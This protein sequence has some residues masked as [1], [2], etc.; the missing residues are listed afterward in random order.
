MIKNRKLLVRDLTLRDGQ[1][2]LFATRMPQ[3]E[4]E[5]VLPLYKKAGFYALEVWGGAVPD[6]VMRYLNE[7]PW[8]RLESIK[9][10]IGDVSK[11]TALSRGRNLFGYSPY[12]ESV[13]EK[14]NT[15][16]VKSGLGIM[17]I[18][19]CL[20][21][22]ENMKSTIKYVKAAGGIADCAVCYTVDSKF[23]EKQEDRD[24]MTIKNL[25]N[26]IFDLEYFVD[27]AKKL[28]AMGAD[29]ISLKDMA[30]LASPSRAGQIIRRFKE[31][32][33][34][35][36]DFHSHSTPGYGLASALTAII[37]GVD[38]IDTNIMNFAGGSAAPAYELI[39]LFCQKLGI[40]LDGDAKT[41][42]EINKILKEIR[43]GALAEVDSY[44]QFP[45]EFDITKDKLPAEI[46][47]LFVDAIEYAKAD[48]EDEL[49]VAC[50]AIEKYFNFPAPNEMVKKAEIPGGMYTNMLNQLKSLGLETLL[51]RVLEVVPVVRL[52]AGCPPLVTPSSQIIGVQAVNCVIDENSGRPFYTN[53]NNQ[54]FNLV[55][56]EYGTT[57]I[58]IA[59]EFRKRIT[60]KAEEAAY[61]MDK[62]QAPENPILSK[63]G[64]VKLAID[65]KE[66]MLLELFPLVAKG[67]LEGKRKVEFEAKREANKKAIAADRS[68]IKRTAQLKIRD[69]TLRDGQQSLFATR[70]PQH[71][72]EKVL[73]FYKDAKFY[74][75]EVWG[76]AIP[77]S[78]M[79]YLNE[80]P[81]YRLESIKEVIGDVSYLTALSRGRNL[82]GY[83]PYPESVIEGFNKNAVKSGLG[84][85]RIFDCLN[86]VKNMET[87]IKYIKEAGGIADCAV[88]Y[89]VDPK[90]TRKQRI[91][92]V[93]SGK[94]LPKKIFDVDYFLNKAKQMEALGADMISVKDMAGLIPPSLSGQIIKRLKKEVKV[95]IDFHTH[96]T[97][98][99]G[100][101]AVL[102]AIINGVDIVDT[103]ILNFAGGPAAPA[104]EII[105]IFADKLGLDTGVDLDAVVKINAELKGIRE[106][107][108]EFDSYKMFPREFD[109]TADYLPA[110]IDALFDK[111]IVLAKADK[112]AE[113][114]EVC[115]AIDVWFNFP[116]PNEEVKAAEIPGGMYTNMLAQLKGLGLE[117]LLPTVLKKVPEVRVAAGCPPLVTPS[118]QIIGVQAVN[119]VLDV[120][121]GKAPY[122]NVNN[123]F[124]N[125][126]KGEYGETPIDIDPDYRQKIC[127]QR[128]ATAYDVSKYKAPENL[129]LEEFGGVKL[130]QNEKEMLLLE[131]FPTV[132]LPYLKNL[133]AEAYYNEQAEIEEQKQRE[134]AERRAAFDG[135]TAEQKE[136]KVLKALYNFEWLSAQESSEIKQPEWKVSKLDQ[137]TIDMLNR[138]KPKSTL[139]D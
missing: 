103:N 4:I 134:A 132:A 81:W 123:Q 84:I 109:I 71:E 3:S 75:M 63:F 18:F 25:P 60:G 122:T 34:V 52:D 12:P 42:V 131:L 116:A 97:P 67:Y 8:Y 59:P 10:E 72:I 32:L 80:D 130:A 88:C 6:S 93:L 76:G 51:E 37:N 41:V 35:P 100:L 27:L 14:F 66:F 77:D 138:E 78:V 139:G 24:R 49:L 137:K 30:G 9:K 102:M 110:D 73:P 83:S 96:C 92:A 114:L 95:P 48:K 119:Y 2:S 136:E 135:M 58:E 86:D 47:K 33:S 91:Q 98:G 17:R 87:T 124:Y 99:Y 128:E 20:N 29:M 118:S 38:I 22:I 61:D 111:A 107:I 19:D 104:F 13:I 79:R 113:L 74:A 120:N 112:E 40:E 57:P 54:F 62:Y 43:L 108:A 68:K 15:Q 53:V 89:T 90:F 64:D 133:R 1:Q 69:L 125:L 50:H 56:G 45:I 101:G 23:P 44:K 105:Q 21:D 70:V 36:V 129:T 28:E 127:G 55:K 26:Q 126:V 106:R 65:D 46:D 16:S 31:E 11:L 85:M 7:D 117:D 39:Y 5:K 94:K 82:F 121:S 115:N